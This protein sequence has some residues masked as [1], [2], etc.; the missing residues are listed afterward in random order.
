MAFIFM[1]FSN[2]LLY[3][4][5]VSPNGA[6]Q[7][8]SQKPKAKSNKPGLAPRRNSSIPCDGSERLGLQQNIFLYHPCV[9]LIF[10]SSDGDS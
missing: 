10:N 7:T 5:S 6:Y 2:A 4:M 9:L 8:L 1:L 3:L